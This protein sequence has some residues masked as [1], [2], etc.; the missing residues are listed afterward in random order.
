[1][2][3]IDLPKTSLKHLSIVDLEEIRCLTERGSLSED[4]ES[5]SRILWSSPALVKRCL[6]LDDTIVHFRK[7]DISVLKDAYQFTSEDVGSF[8]AKNGFLVDLL[9]EAA[10]KIKKYF[11][12]ETR[13]L[14]ELSADNENSEIFARIATQMKPKEALAVLERFDE[15]W[16]FD[17]SPRAKC[18][19]NFALRYV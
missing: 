8:L 7:T 6:G 16:W 14:L 9:M 5:Y 17:A 3:T 13:V 11:G 4:I 19:L 18:L 2:K 1:M 10:P 12:A 15:Q